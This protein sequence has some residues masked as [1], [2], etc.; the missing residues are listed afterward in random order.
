MPDTTH[1]VHVEEGRGFLRL[2]L[3]RPGRYN[4][5]DTATLVA[6]IEALSGAN[7][8]PVPLLLEGDGGVF[9]VGA[10]IP[11]LSRFDAYAATAFSHLGHQVVS[12]LEAWPGVTV[13]RLSGYCLGSGL[14]LALG[15]D[16]IVARADVRIGLPGLAWALMPCL[17]GLR[18]LSVRLDRA[19]CTDLF[20]GGEVLDGTQAHALG[21][22]DRLI[23]TDEDAE[24]LARDNREWSASA[25]AAIRE[26]RLNRHGLIDCGIEAD[27][28]AESFASG[29]CQRRLKQLL[30]S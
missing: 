24:A 28:F 21:L 27:L 9:S 22:V 12:A 11:E 4:A 3:S 5:I 20:L 30:G 1:P 18:R 19:H 10:D 7:R 8:M 6:L 13:A 17:G 14:E 16:L 2:R 23:T 26:M 15:C 25:V 29:E